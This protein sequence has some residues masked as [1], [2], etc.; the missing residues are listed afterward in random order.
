MVQVRVQPDVGETI[1]GQNVGSSSMNVPVLQG[2]KQTMISSVD[3][4]SQTNKPATDPN[5]PIVSNPSEMPVKKSHWWIWLIII[6][7]LLGAGFAAYW[8]IF[9]KGFI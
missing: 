7:V 5:S 6:L 4:P 1:Q 9:K 8:F 3:M 2:K